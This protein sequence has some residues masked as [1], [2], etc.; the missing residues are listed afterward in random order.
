MPTHLAPEST[1]PLRS[2]PVLPYPVGEP[3]DLL[4]IG[5]AT[6]SSSDEPR[7]RTEA[8]LPRPR[9]ESAEEKLGLVAGVVLESDAFASA[10]L[11]M[12]TVSYQRRQCT[13]C[14]FGTFTCSRNTSARKGGRLPIDHRID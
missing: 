3:G 12:S 4:A 6:A 13:G 8:P 1:L 7:P 5:L 2:R 10:R 9:N 11:T 14:V